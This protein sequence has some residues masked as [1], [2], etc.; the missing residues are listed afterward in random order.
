[1]NGNNPTRTGGI[2]DPVAQNIRQ[3]QN[4]AAA[5]SKAEVREQEESEKQLVERLATLVDENV[6]LKDREA[7]I[8][9]A[10][11]HDYDDVAGAARDANSDRWGL[12]LHRAFSI[13]DD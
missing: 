7:V 10:E 5:P 6:Y 4:R 9:A 1:M 12:L 11:T 2:N 8:A 13:A 3:Q